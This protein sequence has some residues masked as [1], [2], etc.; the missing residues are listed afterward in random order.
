MVIAVCMKVAK[1]V[2]GEPGSSRVCEPA[3]VSFYESLES[4]TLQQIKSKPLRVVF[5]DKQYVTQN[6]AAISK[7]EEQNQ[8]YVF[9]DTCENHATAIPEWYAAN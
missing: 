6:N 5:L 9:A 7:L 3:G 2:S 4:C 8:S 1:V